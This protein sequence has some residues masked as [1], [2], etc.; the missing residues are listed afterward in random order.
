[1][2][3]T[4]EQICNDDYHVR[5][6]EVDW[7]SDKSLHNWYE[8]LDLVC[9]PSWK[10]AVA[11]SAFFVGWVST[12]LWIPRLSDKS[13]RKKM[14]VTGMAVS[15]ILYTA[16]LFANS[17]DMMIGILFCL[18]TMRTINLTMSYIYMIELMPKESQTTAGTLYVMIDA[19]IF[20]F[21]TLYFWFVSSHYFYFILIGYAL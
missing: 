19:S 5:N 10:I 20:L 15:S 3:C 21:G 1:M 7:S 13:G 6:W 8:Q 17:L 18:G 11:G 12:L 9:E 2:V 4:K 16:M 14:Q